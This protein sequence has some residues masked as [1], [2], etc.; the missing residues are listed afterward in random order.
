MKI[1][2]EHQHIP[3]GPY[4]SSMRVDS[5]FCTRLLKEG[6]TLTKKNNENLAANIEQEY[7][8]DLEKDLWIKEEFN[9]FIN[10][11]IHGFKQFSGNLK[12]NP[13]YKLNRLWINFQKAGEYNPVHTHP[14]CHVSFILF[15]E[16]PKEMLEEKQ[17]IQGA[18]PG[19]TGFLCGEETYGFL[20]HRI[21]KPEAGLLLMFPNNLKHYVSHFNS[22]VTRISVS[23]NINFA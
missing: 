13:T 10:T 12:F 8:Y 22:K 15:L 19:H 17:I 20:T 18:P 4:L 6:R 11:Y 14:N 21:I 3:F 7:L 23:G 1:L 9:L 5:N 2:N 16:I